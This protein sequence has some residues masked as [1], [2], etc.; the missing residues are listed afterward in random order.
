[1]AL[2]SSRRKGVHTE[3]FAARGSS[4][5]GYLVYTFYDTTLEEF[6]VKYQHAL[7][8]HALLWMENGECINP[9]S[10]LGAKQVTVQ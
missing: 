5:G 6:E 3:V 8:T 9:Y 1:M 7:N 4:G 2:F 10:F